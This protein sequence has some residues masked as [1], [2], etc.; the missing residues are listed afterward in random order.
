MPTLKAKVN[1]RKMIKDRNNRIE[2]EL[3]AKGVPVFDI[4]VDLNIDSSYYNLPLSITDVPSRDL[5]EHINAYT[6]LKAYLRTLLARAELILEERKQI[7]YK[8]TKVLYSDLTNKKVSETAKERI[9]CGEVYDKDCYND[10]M[11][12]VQNVNFLR[13]KIESIEDILFML[14]R[15][16]TRR[17]GDFK[18]ENRAHNVSR[19]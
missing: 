2:E 14:S 13:Y 11:S 16:V 1:P 9:I 10:Y 8:E 6:Q 19:R 5:G 4:D 7:Y 15:E 3:K 17:T 12:A 18:E